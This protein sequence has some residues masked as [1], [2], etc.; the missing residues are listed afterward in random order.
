MAGRSVTY[1][2]VTLAGHT[3]EMCVFSDGRRMLMADDFDR[4][5]DLLFHAELHL[6]HEEYR[7]L[8]HAIEERL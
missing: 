3:L 7:T 6:T 1:E 4:L 5:V 8:A 2:T